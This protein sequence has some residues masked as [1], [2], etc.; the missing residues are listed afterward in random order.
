MTASSWFDLSMTPGTP[1]PQYY[2]NTPLTSTVLS[3]STDGGLDH[4]Q[5]VSTSKHLRIFNVIS[6]TSTGN[7]AYILDYLMFYS[8]IEQGSLDVVDMIN[9]SPLTRSV[10]GEGVQIMAINLGAA[11]GG[12]TFRV[13]YTNELGVSGRLTRPT[14]IN[15]TT[16]IGS[17]ATSNVLVPKDMVDPFLPLQDGDHGV[18]SIESFQMLSGVDV[19]LLALVLVK[20]IASMA[21]ANANTAHE[22]DFLLQKGGTCPVIEN[23]AYLNLVIHPVFSVTGI[24]FMGDITTI[25]S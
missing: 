10:S 3:R 18:R 19:G 24:Q 22:I 25:W 8:F 20:P 13:E 11:T 9:T 21:F 16:A 5:D 6:G 14:K 1:V 23:D 7:T 2:A 15:A 4:G 17:V 12:Q